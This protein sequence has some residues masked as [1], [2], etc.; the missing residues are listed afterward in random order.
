MSQS[1][2]LETATTIGEPTETIRGNNLQHRQENEPSNNLPGRP[3]RRVRTKSTLQGMAPLLNQQQQEQQQ[4]HE[5]EQ[6]STSSPTTITMMMAKPQYY[7]HHLRRHRQDSLDK[8]A[9]M[10]T[11]DDIHCANEKQRLFKSLRRI[12]RRLLLEHANSM[13]SNSNNTNLPTSNCMDN[14]LTEQQDSDQHVDGRKI[15]NCFHTNQ[16]ISFSEY[17]DNSSVDDDDDD[18]DDDAQEEE[19]IDQ[20]S[21]SDD[22]EQNDQFTSMHATTTHQTRYKSQIHYH[23]HQRPME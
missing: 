6:A 7:Y 2:E 19:D 11:Q 5:K 1:S 17:S 22:E 14:T 3:H 18:D 12:K 15:D 21:S 10:S 8:L 20:S 16:T 23:H 13:D 9:T 4:Q